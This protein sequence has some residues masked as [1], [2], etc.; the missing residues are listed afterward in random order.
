MGMNLDE[1]IAAEGPNYEQSKRVLG[2]TATLF[3]DA[4]KL[5]KTLLPLIVPPAGDLKSDEVTTVH[6]MVFECA[7]CGMLLTKSA[8]AMLRMYHGE[9]HVPVRRAIEHCAFA[10]RMS[11]HHELAKVW[12]EAG[13]DAPGEET[14]YWAYRDAFSTS[15]IFPNVGHADHDPLLTALKDRWENCS[16]LI[17]GSVFGMAFHFG[18]VP[19][20]GEEHRLRVAMFDMKP[21]SLIPS[22]FFIVGTH[23][24]VLE[25]FAK[26][27]ARYNTDV[28]EWERE[29]GYFVPKLERHRVMWIDRLRNHPGYA[30]LAN[31]AVRAAAQN[32]LQPA[33]N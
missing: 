25:L 33:Q 21:D 16:K 5:Y 8:L 17:H 3:D 6:S 9:S 13:L 20:D 23:S 30:F 28:A 22:F 24:I 19:E 18:A 14:K 4:D 10:V 7:M 26:A 29:F 15:K 27:F 2:E 31:D 1:H 11:K 12:G 32:P